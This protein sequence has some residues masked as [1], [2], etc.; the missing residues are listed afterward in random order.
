LA[1]AL[2]ESS[3]GALENKRQKS[4]HPKLPV[5]RAFAS[6]APGVTTAHLFNRQG[7]AIK[8]LNGITMAM[9][10]LLAFAIRATPQ[11]MPIDLYRSTKYGIVAEFDS[12]VAACSSLSNVARNLCK[13]LARRQYIVAMAV[14]EASYKPSPEAR[15]KARINI[16]DADYLVAQRLCDNKSGGARNLC[17]R[18]ARGAQMAAKADAIEM[19]ENSNAYRAARNKADARQFTREDEERA[20]A[21]KDSAFEKRNTEFEISKERCDPLTD[22][23]KVACAEE[24]KRRLG[25]S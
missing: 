2:V 8:H 14:L 19:D 21:R 12:S 22:R 25:P 9:I 3:G 10:I 6:I 20:E 23:F 18:E 16:A 11:S 15:Y 4:A 7:T 5:P 13:A 24:S 1:G 17:L